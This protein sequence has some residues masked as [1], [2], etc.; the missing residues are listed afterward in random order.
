MAGQTGRLEATVY[1][2]GVEARGVELLLSRQELVVTARKL[3]P[4]RKN[5]IALSL[6]TCARD[7]RLRIKIPRSQKTANVTAQ[8]E[9][10]V[11]RIR[12]DRDETSA[13]AAA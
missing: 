4:V 8:F 7:Y 10:G 11:L 13:I 12:I 3:H 6:E 5:W 1:L 2:P 9:D